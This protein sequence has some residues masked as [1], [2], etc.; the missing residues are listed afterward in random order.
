MGKQAAKAKPQLPAVDDQGAAQGGAG[1]HEMEKNADAGFDM[2]KVSRWIERL[3]NTRLESEGKKGRAAWAALHA[4]RSVLEATF[5]ALSATD[6]PL[7]AKDAL[8]ALKLVGVSEARGLRNEP[9]AKTMNTVVENMNEQLA[10]L[11]TEVRGMVERRNGDEAQDVVEEEQQTKNQMDKGKRK[12]TATQWAYPRAHMQETEEEQYGAMSDKY[13]QREEL[14]GDGGYNHDGD[15]DGDGV[16]RDEFGRL[17]AQRQELEYYDDM[18]RHMDQR[19]RQVEEKRVKAKEFEDHMNKQHAMYMD[20]DT[21]ITTQQ[22]DEMHYARA[23]HRDEDQRR[24]LRSSQ[25]GLNVR[26]GGIMRMPDEYTWGETHAAK[27][28]R[29]TLNVEKREHAAL[30]PNTAK[31]AKQE[32]GDFLYNMA[33]RQRR[34]P[35]G[36]Y[37]EFMHPGGQGPVMMNNSGNTSKSLLDNMAVRQG[38][39]QRLE[40]PYNVFP[41]PLGAATGNYPR[42]PSP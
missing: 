19:G 21:P 16:W 11:V 23:V 14:Y 13:T 5:R 26:H 38:A 6:A 28:S 18:R 22:Q 7:D 9:T 10:V 37:K 40:E 3:E 31:R 8:T 41:P 32:Q 20:N 42:H 24:T 2:E 29:D 4:A 35:L 34:E 39:E 33:Q 15:Y 25:G 36:V 27:L 17:V 12:A 30:N 1:G